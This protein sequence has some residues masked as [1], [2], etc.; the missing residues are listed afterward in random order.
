MGQLQ[1]LWFR[2]GFS[3]KPVTI[4][5]SGGG[6]G[7]WLILGRWFCKFS[8]FAKISVMGFLENPSLPQDGFAN[9]L[10]L[11][12]RHSPRMDLQILWICKPVTPPGVFYLWNQ[13]PTPRIWRLSVGELEFIKVPSLKVFHQAEL[14]SSA[15]D[16]AQASGSGFG[17]H[18]QGRWPTASMGACPVCDWGMVSRITSQVLFKTKPFSVAHN[19]TL[20]CILGGLGKAKRRLCDCCAVKGQERTCSIQSC[21]FQFVPDPTG[22]GHSVLWGP[23]NQASEQ[24]AFWPALFFSNLIQ[25]Q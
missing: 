18:L 13:W 21:S 25:T 19:G 4:P 8:R 7:V 5:Y 1:N 22:R 6:A 17:L 12:T 11:Q 10:D 3:R 23:Q 20:F 2:D 24:P 15:S 9:F 16:T 14:L